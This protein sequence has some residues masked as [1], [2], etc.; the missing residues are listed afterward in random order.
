MVLI[1]TRGRI[2]KDYDMVFCERHSRESFVES[3]HEYQDCLA[4]C[5]WG[6]DWQRAGYQEQCYHQ[7]ALEF[8]G[9]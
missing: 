4:T 6:K 1:S 8:G 9:G 2:S 5:F 3:I 7:V